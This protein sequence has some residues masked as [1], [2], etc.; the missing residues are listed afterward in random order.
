MSAKSYHIPTFNNHIDFVSS[1]RHLYGNLVQMVN[2]T[3]LTGVSTTTKVWVR[4]LMDAFLYNALTRLL[5]AERIFATSYI[6]VF[7]Q[8][9][10][11]K[12]RKRRKCKLQYL[13][14]DI[15]YSMFKGRENF[16]NILWSIL[17][18]S[19]RNVYPTSKNVEK[20]SA[21][22]VTQMNQSWKSRPFR[23]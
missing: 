4:S 20:I 21:N 3:A 2:S 11:C 8:L 17:Q 15:C 5:Y 12:E 16:V 22:I 6:K 18:V 19:R 1:F 7:V 14:I 23:C 13:F 10:F 9:S